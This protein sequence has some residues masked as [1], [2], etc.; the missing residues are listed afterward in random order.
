MKRKNVSVEEEFFAYGDDEI[1][2]VYGRNGKGGQNTKTSSPLAK[3]IQVLLVLILLAVLVVLGI[4]GYMY[5]KKALLGEEKGSTP[6]AVEKKTSNPPATSQQVQQSVA[7]KS[8]QAA[9]VA[10]QIQQKVQKSVAAS[11]VSSVAQVVPAVQQASSVQQHSSALAQAQSSVVQQSSSAPVT[12]TVQ[13]EKSVSEMSDE[14]LI[15]YLRSLKPDQ[16]KKLNIEE[17]ILA[18]KK[19]EQGKKKENVAVAKT[20]YLNNQLVL[21]KNIKAKKEENSQIAALSQQLAAI[22]QT[23]PQKV[24]NKQYIKGLE[25]EA[26]V[27]EEINRYY[28]VMPGDSLSKIAKKFYGKASEYIKIYE[29]NQDIIKDPRLIYPGQKLRIPN[30]Q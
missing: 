19:R 2:G 21:D 27:R 6:V 20:E 8:Q 1:N 15:A 29:A 12:T 3:V 25:K 24:A 5:A 26:K 10:S 30:V 4:I 28:I 13:K 22:V 9:S 11:L 16:L 17:L 23:T 18:R 7:P 14:E